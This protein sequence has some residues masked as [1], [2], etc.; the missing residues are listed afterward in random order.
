MAADPRSVSLRV[1]AAVTAVATAV[2]CGLAGLRFGATWQLPAFLLLA[3]VGVL[4]AVIDLEHRLLPNR[5][6]LPA[7][8]AAAALLTG[9]AALTG[10]WS[11]VAEA[12]ACAAVLFLFFFV[13]ALLAPAGLGMGDVKLAGFLGLYLGWVGPGALAVGAVAGFVVQAML[14][15]A[16]LAARRVG[17]KGEIPFGPALLGGAAIAIGWGPEL[18]TAWLGTT[19]GM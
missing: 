6:L 4:L 16:L 18:I 1:P 7:T 8:A 9:A 3:V 19:G 5:V 13:L 17:V 11:R 14:A 15:L 12:V 2:L 10:S